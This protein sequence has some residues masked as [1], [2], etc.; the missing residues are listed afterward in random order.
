MNTFI[1]QNDRNRHEENVREHTETDLWNG[2]G[3]GIVSSFGL[4]NISQ[5]VQR[6]RVTH[7]T[8]CQC[9]IKLAASGRLN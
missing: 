7:A 9:E 4:N 5:T 8:S 3:F 6:E 1:R 2:S